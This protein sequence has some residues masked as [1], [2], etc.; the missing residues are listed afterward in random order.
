MMHC[1][2]LEVVIQNY[3]AVPEDLRQRAGESLEVLAEEPKELPPQN[4]SWYCIHQPSFDQTR[5]DQHALWKGWERNKIRRGTRSMM[6]RHETIIGRPTLCI[7][8]FTWDWKGEDENEGPNR[9]RTQ[10]GE[11]TRRGEEN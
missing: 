5:E 1:R 8:P 2:H 11:K 4:K 6:T 10:E 7:S 9:R 3:E